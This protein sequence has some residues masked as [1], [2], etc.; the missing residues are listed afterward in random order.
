ME[1]AVKT[2]AGKFER[3]GSFWERRER[4]EHGPGI[5]HAP[6]LVQVESDAS[7]VTATAMVRS[8]RLATTVRKQFIIAVVNVES[9]RVDFLGFDWWRA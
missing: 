5:D 7:Q 1:R 4:Y 3:Q 9:R 6:Y 2:P 8:G